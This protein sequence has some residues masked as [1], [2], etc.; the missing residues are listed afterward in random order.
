MKQIKHIL[1]LFLVYCLVAVPFKVMEVIPGFTDIRPVTLLG[2][3]FALFFGLTGC[4]VM[5]FG[6][7]LMDLVSDSLRWS[8]IAG[9]AANFLGPW[10]VWLYWTRISRTG[11]SLR[12]GR[13][14]L[15]HMGILLLAAVLE[16]AVITPAVALI[17]PEVDAKLFALSVLGNT[18]LFPVAFG[19]PLLILLQEELGFVPLRREKRESSRP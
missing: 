2:P 11:F 18:F 10:L 12:T 4:W 17:Y 14:L 3:V 5:A 19:I 9:F 16:A 6:N 8:S 15:R 1:L 13:N 7:L